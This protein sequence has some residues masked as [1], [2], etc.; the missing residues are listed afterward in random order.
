MMCDQNKKEKETHGEEC[1]FANCKTMMF[2]TSQT[3]HILNVEY[4]SN[5]THRYK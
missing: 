5:E 4:V 1:N 2:G 3:S